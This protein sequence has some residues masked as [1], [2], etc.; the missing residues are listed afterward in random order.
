MTSECSKRNVMRPA[1]TN[2]TVPRLNPTISSLADS[3]FPQFLLIPLLLL[4]LAL[5]LPQLLLAP[6]SFGLGQLLPRKLFICL[7]DTL[8]LGLT[9]PLLLFCHRNALQLQLLQIFLQR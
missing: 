6:S 4:H 5:L 3:H 2:I 9:L 1:S 8:G 7:S